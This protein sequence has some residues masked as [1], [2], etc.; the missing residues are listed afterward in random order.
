MTKEVEEFENGN[1]V[2]AASNELAD[3]AVHMVGP[4]DAGAALLGAALK[5]W[6]RSIGN[7]GAFHM[8]QKSL[9]LIIEAQSKPTGYN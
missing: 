1:A 8:A 9:G 7:E 6:D 4:D 5:A 3:F 2:I